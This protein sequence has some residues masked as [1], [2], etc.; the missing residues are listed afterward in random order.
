[1]VTFMSPLIPGPNRSTRMVLPRWMVPPVLLAMPSPDGAFVPRSWAF[2][3]AAGGATTTSIPLCVCPAVRL[4]GVGVVDGTDGAA[5]GV[6]EPVLVGGVD[7]VLVPAPTT[8][9]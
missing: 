9:L 8:P 2:S 1:M 5:E 7:G 6:A 4:T 3:V